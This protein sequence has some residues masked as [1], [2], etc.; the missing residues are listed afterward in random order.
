M[1]ILVNPLHYIILV[2]PMA[3]TDHDIKI[4]RDIVSNYD[5]GDR[6][7][8]MRSIFKNECNFEHF[9]NLGIAIGEEKFKELKDKKDY[10][11]FHMKT[12]SYLN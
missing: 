8:V 11:V 3:L 6:V 10:E 2:S 12:I 5:Q 7:R 9:I 4:I 1:K